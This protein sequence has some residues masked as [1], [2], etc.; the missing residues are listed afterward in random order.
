MV[1]LQVLYGLQYLHRN[2]IVHL[3]LQPSS[4]LLSAPRGLDIKLADFS[5]AQVLT[6]GA[7]EVAVPRKG[8]PDFIGGFLVQSFYLHDL[9]GPTVLI[10]ICPCFPLFGVCVCVCVCV[11]ACVRACVCVCMRVC[12][13]ACVCVCVCMRVCVC[14]CVRACVCVCVHACVCVCMRV[15]VCVRACGRACVRAC[16]RARVW[17]CLCGWV[18]VCCF[19]CCFFTLFKT[20]LSNIL[21]FHQEQIVLML[22]VLLS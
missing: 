21:C 18:W 3:N 17:M 22:P 7:D 1:L 13:C 12:V 11:R 4:L 8:Y 19:V 6:N 20:F 15:C 9:N 16:T 14:A 10:K 5:L 2:S